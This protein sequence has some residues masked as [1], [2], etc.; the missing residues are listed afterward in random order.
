M[1]P[2][3]QSSRHP[4][5]HP[6]LFHVARAIAQ[7]INNMAWTVI[8]W[9]LEAFDFL[10][11]MLIINPWTFTP[12]EAG[13]Y[14]LHASTQIMDLAAG[15]IFA[16]QFYVDGLVGGHVHEAEVTNLNEDIYALIDD[17]LYLTPNNVVDVRVWHN[18]GAIRTIGGGLWANIFHGFRVM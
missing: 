11:E 2:L 12:I 18:F 6:S 10:D 4:K 1:Q 3:S 17:I 8:Q 14:K 16:A 13:Y 5:H 15:D 7:N 9:D